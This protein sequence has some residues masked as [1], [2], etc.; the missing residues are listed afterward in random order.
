MPPL[1]KLSS[2]CS[3]PPPAPAMKRIQG[4]RPVVELD[5]LQR[6]SWK[7]TTRIGI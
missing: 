6:A 7:R 3:P 5:L 1:K 4:A 2:G